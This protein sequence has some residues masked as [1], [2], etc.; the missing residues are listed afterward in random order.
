MN[1]GPTAPHARAYTHVLHHPW[2]FCGAVGVAYFV[3]EVHV[4]FAQYM[5]AEKSKPNQMTVKY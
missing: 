4:D 1:S 2:D 5:R 3:G